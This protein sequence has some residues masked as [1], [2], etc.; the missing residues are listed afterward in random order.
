MML[1]KGCW[2]EDM[3]TFI[4]NIVRLA[5]LMSLASLIS[6]LLGWQS[7][8]EVMIAVDLVMLVIWGT[9]EYELRMK[10]KESK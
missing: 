2:R 1:I 3:N 9:S 8:N 7:A 5:A 6:M 10:R 4:N